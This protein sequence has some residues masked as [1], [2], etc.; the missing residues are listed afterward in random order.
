MQELLEASD[1]SVVRAFQIDA[2]E[3]KQDGENETEAKERQQRRVKT[4]W[5][6]RKRLDAEME[7]YL[8]LHTWI[9]SDL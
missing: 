5:D 7:V 6:E 4:F 8:N 9:K 1:Q 3:A 2:K